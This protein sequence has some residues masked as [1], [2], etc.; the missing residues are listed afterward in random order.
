MPRPTMYILSG[1]QGSGKSTWAKSKT[2]AITVS[3]DDYFTVGSSYHF[4]HTKLGKAHAE[5]FRNAILTVQAN[6]DCIVDNTNST[7]LEIAPYYQLAK[8]YNYNVVIVK[9]KC[10]VNKAAS[11]NV[12]GVPEQGVKATASRCANLKLPPYWDVE[13]EEVET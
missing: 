9:V 8:A 3:A 11:R 10:D 12:H 4:D 1:C 5:C 6:Q 7:T 2:S 13:V